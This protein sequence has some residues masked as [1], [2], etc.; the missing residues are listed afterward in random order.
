MPNS[1][2][3]YAMY[4]RERPT[5]ST[6]RATQEKIWGKMEDMIPLPTLR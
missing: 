5:V 6:T 1:D 4:V 2:T 3:D